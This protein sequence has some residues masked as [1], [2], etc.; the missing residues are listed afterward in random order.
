[1]G[2]DERR[3]ACGVGLAL[4][5]LSV[6]RRR[7]AFGAALEEAQTLLEPLDPRAPSAVAIGN[8]VRAV[9]L[10]QLGTTAL[11][12]SRL[13]EAER[14]L[15]RGLELAQLGRRPYLEMQFLAH[16]AVVAG[17]RS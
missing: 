6:A 10:M 9:A 7:G 12:S 15:E 4:T 13:E 11:W 5:G 2:R 3:R 1:K 14:H 17:H 8:D 16:L